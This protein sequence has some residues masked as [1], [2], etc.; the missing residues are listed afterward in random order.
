MHRTPRLMPAGRA[1]PDRL[2]AATLSCGVSCFPEHAQ[3]PDALVRCA[4]VA[5]FAAGLRAVAFDPAG[6]SGPAL[7]LNTVPSR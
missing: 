4:D 6:A 5:F 2:P 7:G 3:S 1:R